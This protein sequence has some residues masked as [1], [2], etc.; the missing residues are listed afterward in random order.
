VGRITILLA[1]TVAAMA[2]TPATAAGQELTYRYGPVTLGPHEVDQNTVLGTVPKP[3]SDGF[4]THMEVDLVDERGQRVSPARVMLHH[5]VFL[6]L[7]EPGKFDHRDWTCSTFTGLDGKTKVPALADRFYASGEERNV[8]QL[9]DGYGYKVSGKD[10]W[11]L[12]WMLMNHRHVNDKVFI[13]YRISYETERQLAPAYMVW[14][15]VRN[16][17]SDPVFDAPGGGLP[18]ST[19][20]QATTWTAPTS[21]RLVAGG[22][23]VHGGGRNVVLSQPDCGD[24]EL[25]TSRPLYGLPDNPVYRVTPVLHEPGPESMSGFLSSQGLPLERGQ[26]LKLTANYD[27][28]YPHTRVM[29]IMGVY[30]VPDPGVTNACGP[31]PLLETYASGRPGR[32]DP[33][34]FRVPLPRKPLGRLWRAG[35]SAT[36]RVRDFS[37]DK[38]R[39]RVPRGATVRWKFEGSSF[40]NVTV[41]TGPRGFSSPNTA[42]GRTFR[43]RLKTPG[44][45][46]LFCTVH[47]TE[48]VQEIRV[49]KRR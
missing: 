8:L 43:A 38:E 39:L 7:G 21:G 34:R 33:P 32:S 18:R 15:D 22:G 14:L 6:N 30:F 47:P 36:V 13:E 23:H 31:L 20:S 46:R 19:F 35:R 26:R 48:M 10:N 5:I 42:A 1:V 12:L 25:F 2:A 27:N 40:H 11:V 45:Y 9:P 24:R 28:R 3:S 17:L 4:I 16:C 44:T 37:F 29:G 49:A 41:A